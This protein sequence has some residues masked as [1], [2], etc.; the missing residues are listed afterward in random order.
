MSWKDFVDSQENAADDVIGSVLGTEEP[1]DGGMSVRDRAIA[2][3]EKANLYRVLLEDNI[4]SEGSARPEILNEVESEIKA[5]IESRLLTLLGISPEPTQ[6][7]AQ[8][9]FNED[10]LKALTMLADKVV[11]STANAVKSDPVPPTPSVKKVSAETVVM[12]TPKISPAAP[13]PSIAKKAE[14]A[15]TIA[16]PV[17]AP[18]PTS[19]LPPAGTS[20]KPV[21]KKDSPDSKVAKTGLKPN[22]KAPKPLPLPSIDQQSMMYDFERAAL[23]AEGTLVNKV[24]DRQ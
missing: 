2:Q 6:K 20:K 16:K 11:G 15:K 23:E 1:N 17:Q 7:A 19:S 9:P 10:Q 4:F 14:P 22:P 8:L 13:I 18:R 5:F 24:E 3:M 12:P 21:K